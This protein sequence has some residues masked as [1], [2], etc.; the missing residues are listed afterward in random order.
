ML[1]R[2]D[3]VEFDNAIRSV[4]LERGWQAAIV[5]RQLGHEIAVLSVALVM[6]ATWHNAF[7]FEADEVVKV[8]NLGVVTYGV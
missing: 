4:F 1:L 3:G 6:D 2:G 8:D 5:R 7:A